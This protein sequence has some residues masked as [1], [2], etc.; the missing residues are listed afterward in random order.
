M[1]KPKPS[2]SCDLTDEQKNLLLAHK[3]V[4]G[5]ADSDDEDED[6][7]DSTRCLVKQ[8]RAMDVAEDLARGH[9]ATKLLTLLGA[10]SDE[11]ARFMERYAA[12]RAKWA[13]TASGLDEEEEDDLLDEETEA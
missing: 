8:L 5:N 7:G 11:K 12:T 6:E 13:R 2:P 10:P 1:L 4:F 3:T 9:A